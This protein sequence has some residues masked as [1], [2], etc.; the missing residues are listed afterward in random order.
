MDSLNSIVVAAVG[1]SQAR[2]QQ[3]LAGRL[4]AISRAQPE[5]PGVIEAA[6]RASS[7]ADEALAG[8]IEALGAA[9]DTYG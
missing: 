1:L 7:A 4:L 2:F 3:A 8:V 9:V 5:A 6:G